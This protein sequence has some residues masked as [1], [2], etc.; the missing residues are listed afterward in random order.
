M[1]LLS[2]IG[3]SIKQVYTGISQAIS[4]QNAKTVQTPLITKTE[5]VA[6]P[7]VQAV[8]DVAT[9]TAFT[10]VAQVPTIIKAVTTATSTA[11][12]AI[13]KSASTYA[14]TNPIK[15][16]AGGIF[17]GGVLLETQKPLETAVQIPNLIAEGG[18]ATGKS[19]E[20][21]SIKPLID[22]GQSNPEAV[23]IGGVLASYGL[24]KGTKGLI[25]AKIVS[26]II[27]PDESTGGFSPAPTN[28]LPSLPTIPAPKEKDVLPKD[29]PKEKEIKTNEIVPMTPET[30]IIGKE[31]KSLTTARKRYKTTKKVGNM[32]SIR[33]NIYNQS[34]HLYTKGIYN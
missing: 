34:K 27:S 16:I 24:I 11:A 25:G 12:K 2:N 7:Y 32:Q 15:T 18:K 14:S 17:T 1:G 20:E 4:G 31:T 21:G 29:L 5:K 23:L 13:A 28:F 3:S 30:Q 10:K 33:L 9:V 8:K 26:D 6:G 22:F 19:I